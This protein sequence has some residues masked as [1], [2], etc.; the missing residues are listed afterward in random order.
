MAGKKPERRD[1]F[2]KKDTKFVNNSLESLF[3]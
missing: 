2:K 3:S 1:N